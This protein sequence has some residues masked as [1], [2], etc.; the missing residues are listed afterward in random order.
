MFFSI[1]YSIVVVKVKVSCKYNREQY[2]KKKSCSIK[3]CN[4]KAQVRLA[5]HIKNYHPDISKAK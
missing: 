3:G 4:A 5:V 1:M 2:R